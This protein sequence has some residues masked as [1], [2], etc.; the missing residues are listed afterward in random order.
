MRVRYQS[1]L[2]TLDG[3]AGRRVGSADVLVDGVARAAMPALH[4]VAAGRGLACSQPVDVGARQPLGRQLDDR[5]AAEPGSP[6]RNGSTDPV[7]P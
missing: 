3:E 1:E 4:A 7:A 6:N 5:I 2:R